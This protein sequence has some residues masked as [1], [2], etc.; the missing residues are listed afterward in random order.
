[1]TSPYFDTNTDFFRAYYEQGLPYEAY[2]A[3][4]E[5][6]Q[7]ARVREVEGLI[8]LMPAQA[9]LLASYT[10]QMRVLVLSGLW[11]GDCTRQV[12]MFGLIERACSLIQMRY[13]DSRAH[14]D[15]HNMLRINGALKVPV[16]VTLSED[17]FELSRFGDRHL[18][19]YRRKAATECGPACDA[20]IVPPPEDALN[21]ELGEWCD[22][23]ERLQH[24]LR[25]APMLRQRYGD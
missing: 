21:T 24:M 11:C 10:R 2:V 4:G 18:S 3:G 20:G 8:A 15:L 12:P 6:N 16:V 17:F 7:L 13:L 1:M 19:V 5:A 23:F 25:L 14:P 9:A 22:H